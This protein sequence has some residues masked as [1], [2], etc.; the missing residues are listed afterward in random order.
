[1]S[2]GCKQQRLTVILPLDRRPSLDG[3]FA[4]AAVARTRSTPPR[5]SPLAAKGS[6]K[7]QGN[8]T[9][10][11]ENQPG[12]NQSM[13]RGPVIFAFAPK[14]GLKPANRALTDATRCSGRQQVLLLLLFFLRA[15][16]EGICF[17]HC[18]ILLCW[19][20]CKRGGNI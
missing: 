15:L 9:S 8:A 2:K 3:P 19:L 1:M 6:G 7:H 5:K 4:A 16:G 20:L 12:L 11:H 10:R 18:S 17:F 13:P 14:R